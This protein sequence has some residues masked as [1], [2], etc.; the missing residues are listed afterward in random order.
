MVNTMVMPVLTVMA[1]ALVIIATVAP[2]LGLAP[3]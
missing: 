3:G 1:M 2:A